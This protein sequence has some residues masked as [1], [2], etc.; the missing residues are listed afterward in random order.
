MMITKWTS[1][2]SVPNV[3]STTRCRESQ[4]SLAVVFD[5]TFVSGGVDLRVRLFIDHRRIVSFCCCCCC[6]VNVDVVVL[7]LCALNFRG[8]PQ[9]RNSKIFP[10][11]ATGTV[12]YTAEPAIFRNSE[13]CMDTSL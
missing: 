6:F 10:D 13:M 9:P 5:R 11:L 1:A 8:W 3:R 2:W 12:G 4:I 7:L